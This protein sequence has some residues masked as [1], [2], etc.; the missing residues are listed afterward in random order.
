MVP[1]IRLL[2]LVAY[3]A[4]ERVLGCKCAAQLRQAPRGAGQDH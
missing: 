4:L 1:L 3:T 2:A